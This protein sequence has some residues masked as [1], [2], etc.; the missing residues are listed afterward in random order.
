[1]VLPKGGSIWSRIRIKTKAGIQAS[2]HLILVF[3]TGS[4]S[5]SPKE[6]TGVWPICSSGQTK[7]QI[8]GKHRLGIMASTYWDMPNGVIVLSVDK[9]SIQETYT[10]HVAPATFND[11]DRWFIKRDRHDPNELIYCIDKVEVSWGVPTPK[12]ATIEERM[13]IKANPH[14]AALQRATDGWAWCTSNAGQLLPNFHNI[15]VEQ[16]N[17]TSY[18]GAKY[19]TW[20][21]VTGE[22]WDPQTK[23]E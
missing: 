15:E 9:N 20:H 1:M 16:K 4:G 13:P 3:W 11:K 12:L 21:E 8:R 18:R 14:Y 22:F 5:K 2:A 19:H 6:P 7:Q 23:E 10:A 17:T